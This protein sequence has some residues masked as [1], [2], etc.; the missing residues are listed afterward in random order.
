MEILIGEDNARYLDAKEA[1][2][3]MDLTSRQLARLTRFGYFQRQQVGRK[4][5]YK[6]DDLL[7]YKWNKKTNT[8]VTRK[9]LTLL[10]AKVNRLANKLAA[11][12]RI[13]DLYYEPLELEI[14]E[15]RALY[16]NAQGREFK[17]AADLKYWAEICIRLTEQ[18]FIELRESTNDARCWAPF[19]EIAYTGYCI[20]KYKK[21]R[22]L[23]I[24]FKKAL[25][26]IKQSAI[27]FLQLATK[28]HLL[29]KIDK[30]ELKRN[31]KK[32]FSRIH[33]NHLE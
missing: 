22:D 30:A 19:Y 10:T 6:R 20:A 28:D 31:A 25:T 12:E 4:F 23:V 32:L 13:L 1:A 26:N 21:K 33:L 3:A 7:S 5:Y 18:H 8:P 16:T 15:L 2:K 11:V 9:T 17:R 24:L 29:L 27:I 14:R